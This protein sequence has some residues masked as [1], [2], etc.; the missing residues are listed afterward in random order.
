MNIEE[1]Q[2][3]LK[4]QLKEQARTIL[5][6]EKYKAIR[7]VTIVTNEVNGRVDIIAQNCGNN[8]VMTVKGYLQ[9]AIDM[10]NRQQLLSNFVAN[11]QKEENN[12]A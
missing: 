3:Q 2:E 6:Q 1:V 12:G 7:C 5:S 8:L 10:L 9:E 4:E 11:K